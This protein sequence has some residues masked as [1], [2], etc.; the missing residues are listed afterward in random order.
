MPSSQSFTPRIATVVACALFALLAF[1]CDGS[2]SGYRSPAVPDD[3]PPTP[4]P[5]PATNVAGAWS[6]ALTVIWDGGP[7]GAGS[8]AGPATATFWQ[9]GSVV[10]GR[11]FNTAAECEELAHRH[12]FV[13]SLEGDALHGNIG[14][15]AIT[16]GWPTSGRVEGG[17]LTLT[18]YS[19]I[20][21]GNGTLNMRWELRR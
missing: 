4:P 15:G 8:C 17:Q 9:S 6:G 19:T 7:Y 13:G 10:T 18:A 21:N 11:L 12:E 2:G 3:A 20:N 16:P 1:G 14:P 5:P